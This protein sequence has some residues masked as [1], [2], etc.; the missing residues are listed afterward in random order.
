MKEKKPKAFWYKD[1]HNLHGYGTKICNMCNE[2]K[3]IEYFR[4]YF[5]LRDKEPL[6]KANVALLPYGK[7]QITYWRNTCMKCEAK[8]HKKGARRLSRTD[9]VDYFD[10]DTNTY[11]KMHVDTFAR[12]REE[13]RLK[14]LKKQGGLK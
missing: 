3:S 11:K 8:V 2:K 12:L 5:A 9:W 1:I 13:R 4:R 14:Q 7:Y 6:K 10:Y